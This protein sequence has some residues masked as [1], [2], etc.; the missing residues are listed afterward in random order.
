MTVEGN[1][2]E[3]A[4]NNDTPQLDEQAGIHSD[5]LQEA[6]PPESP[7]VDLTE[8]SDEGLATRL[9]AFEDR[10]DLVG[11]ELRERSTLMEEVM[12]RAALVP[13]VDKFQQRLEELEENIVERMQ[14]AQELALEAMP[15]YSYEQKP[16]RVIARATIT[17]KIYDELLRI[18]SDAEL[19]RI[20]R[21]AYKN[22]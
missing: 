17:V 20:R 8:L 12:R 5:Q 21:D 6:Q 1:E 7:P 13:K 4:Q 2:G 11:H 10:Y 18:R 22:A 15:D 16:E 14:R 19:I 3:Q 9:N